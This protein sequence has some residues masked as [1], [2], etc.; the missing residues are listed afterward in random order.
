MSQ[1][2]TERLHSGSVQDRITKRRGV[3]RERELF[4]H[5]ITSV[6]SMPCTARMSLRR[7]T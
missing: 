2:G 5:P 4:G 1:E 7:I 3:E 6:I